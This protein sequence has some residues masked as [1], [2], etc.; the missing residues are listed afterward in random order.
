MGF[1]IGSLSPS[2]TVLLISFDPAGVQDIANTLSGS[3]E[4][5]MRFFCFV[6]EFVYETELTIYLPSARI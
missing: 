4:N 5:Q 6:Y 2:L 3:L 1:S